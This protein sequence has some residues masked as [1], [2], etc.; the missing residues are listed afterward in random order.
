MRRHEEFIFALNHHAE[1][2]P[3]EGGNYC[4]GLCNV[5]GTE[6]ADGY[7]P[8]CIEEYLLRSSM[9]IGDASVL[10]CQASRQIQAVMAI[11]M[12]LNPA[13]PC[14]H[15]VSTHI[16]RASQFFMAQLDAALHLL[17]KSQVIDEDV[18][19]RLFGY[20]V[21]SGIIDEP[22][23]FALGFSGIIQAS[24]RDCVRR[25]QFHFSN[26]EIGLCPG[27]EY[28]TFALSL[29]TLLCKKAGTVEEIATAI[30]ATYPEF[31]LWKKKVVFLYTLLLVVEQALER[32]K[33][34]ILLLVD[35]TQRSL[36]HELVE[37]LMA[38]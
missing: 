20:V 29:A 36:F 3:K 15:S 8:P 4:P 37:W 19:D 23:F 2:K 33:K 7:S 25:W 6:S 35:S 10:L 18:N 14:Q 16:E 11:I 13:E 30:T 34:D 26:D 38:P 28:Y 27:G 31:F 22:D 9:T 1:G 24:V 5:N 32:E 17:I 12:G 21:S